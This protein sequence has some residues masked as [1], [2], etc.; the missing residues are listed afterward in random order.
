MV[1]S[2]GTKSHI[3]PMD[4]GVT[5]VF[6]SY[7]LQKTFIRLA[8]DTNDIKNQLHLK[9]FWRNHY[10]KRAIDSIEDAWEEESQSC[11]NGVWK[12]I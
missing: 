3:Q 6:K 2:P 12:N 11:M 10:S 9:D 4:W 1:L 7:Y 5:A 8:K